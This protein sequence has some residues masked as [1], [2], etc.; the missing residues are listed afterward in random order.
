MAQIKMMR[1]REVQEIYK[2]SEHFAVPHKCSGCGAIWIVLMLPVFYEDGTET[3]EQALFTDHDP[4]C[5]ICGQLIARMD[6]PG[7]V[8]VEETNKGKDVA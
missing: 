4:H 5:K 3:G 7:R 8:K 2:N 6:K 1:Y